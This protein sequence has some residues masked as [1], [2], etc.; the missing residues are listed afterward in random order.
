MNRVQSTPATNMS[1]HA[2]VFAKSSPGSSVTNAAQ[3]APAQAKNNDEN[4]ADKQCEAFANWMN[5]TFQ[6]SEDKDHEASLLDESGNGMEV[7]DRAALRT[8]ILH[9][10]MAQVRTRAMDLFTGD[11]M[12][13]AQR[14]IHV[15]VSK[16]RLK[17]RVD[18]DMY[19]DLTLRGQIISLLL[20]YTTPWLRL[21]LETIFGETILPESPNHFSP[22]KPGL[23]ALTRKADKVRVRCYYLM[24]NV[25]TVAIM[26][27]NV[28]LLEFEQVPLSRMKL[29]LKGFIVNRVLSDPAT[30]NKYTNGRCKVPSGN[31]ETKFKA[32]MRFLTLRRLLTLIVFLDRAKVANVLDR[33]PMLF[34]KTSK[35]KSS[36]DV[37][38]RLCRDFL[39]SE[40]DIIKHLSRIGITVSY[41]QTAIDEVDYTVENLAIDLR[42]GVRLARATEILT[43]EEPK[44][45]L[46]KLRL[47]A[48]SRLQKL[49]NVGSVITIL[50]EKGVPGLEDV[51]PHHIVDAHKEMVLKLMWSILAYCGLRTILNAQA[52]E[53]EIQSV[54]R[55]NSSRRPHWKLGLDTTVPSDNV[56]IQDASVGQEAYYK[57]LL[58]RWVNAICSC[59]GRTASDFASSFADGTVLCL[60]IHYYHPGHLP[61]DQILPTT[62]HLR[63]DDADMRAQALLRE[64]RNFELAQATIS[65]LGGIPKMIT[66]ANSDC[67]PEENSMFLS[68]AYLCSRLMESSREILACIR[69][70]SCYCRYKRRVELEKKLAAASIILDTWRGKKR[71][72]YANQERIYE[73]SVRII[74]NFLLSVKDQLYEM[75]RQRLRKEAKACA[76]TLIQ[77]RIDQHKFLHLVFTCTFAHSFLRIIVNQSLGPCKTNDQRAN[78]SSRSGS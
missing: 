36:R 62:R 52:I 77:V 40:G 73:K 22:Q 18:R 56:V 26:L 27:T 47:P 38:V 13:M 61:L 78:Y 68:V 16:R 69:I 42:D 25:V 75:R 55:A 35:V 59:F 24:C 49:H 53:Q 17:L 76:A 21:G 57:T 66:T 31:F 11:K 37:L 48:V 67:P 63:T 50:R 15:E 19:A 72:Y 58:L 6:P 34:S 60:V 46:V 71:Q 65:E 64:T 12:Q 20:S 43:C 7:R 33:V 1:Q 74:E 10:R 23:A 45:I 4:W 28:L 41:K 44:S 14:A 2:T 54:L 3:A 5:Y 39:S 51:A 29:T 30:L 9:R 70:Q 8:L 32:E